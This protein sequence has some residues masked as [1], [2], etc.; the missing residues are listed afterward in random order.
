MAEVSFEFEQLLVYQ[1]A[2]DFAEVAY[3]AS[4]R[5]PAY[6][7]YGLRSQLQ[8][9]GT[10]IALNIAEGAVGTEAQFRQ[11]LGTAARSTR[12]CV[13]IA[14][15]ATR[16]D[17]FDGKQREYLCERLAELARMLTGLSNSLGRHQ[18]K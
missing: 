15:V 16:V 14:E 17:Y 8:R 18:S 6:E 4:A 10:S 13:A 7:R 2:I 1:K 9:A 12:E 11:F 5:M 3:K